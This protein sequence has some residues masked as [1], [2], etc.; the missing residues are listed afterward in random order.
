[1]S[2]FI[3]CKTC[4]GTGA[5][6][7]QEETNCP[8]CSGYGRERIYIHDNIRKLYGDKNEA[9]LK[10]AIEYALLRNKIVYGK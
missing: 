5:D 3:I 6:P 9:I 7:W 10:K 4:G 8:S 1:M 2:E